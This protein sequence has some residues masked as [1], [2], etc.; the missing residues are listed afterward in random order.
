MESQMMRIF[1]MEQ[2]EMLRQGERG[3]GFRFSTRPLA[4][5]GPAVLAYGCVS[6]QDLSTRVEDFVP[7]EPGEE[8]MLRG[9]DLHTITTL[10]PCEKVHER[11]ITL[12]D[13]YQWIRFMAYW[14]KY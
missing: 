4:L 9:S 7:L 6:G 12:D 3:A 14:L 1:T 13:V 2:G 10:P 11:R 5:V 8:R